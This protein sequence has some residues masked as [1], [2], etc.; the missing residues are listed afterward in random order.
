[1]K[2]Q[3]NV[4][5]VHSISHPPMTRNAVAKIFDVE[6]A[7]ES[8]GEKTAKRSDKGRKDGHDENM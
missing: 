5:A 4:L 2:C 1:M 6:S 8:G 3:P 7:L